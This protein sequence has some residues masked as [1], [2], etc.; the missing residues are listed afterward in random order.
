MA[1][2]YDNFFDFPSGARCAIR[3]VKYISPIRKDKDFKYYF[4]VFGDG[5][6]HREEFSYPVAPK[7]P[8]P[9]AQCRETRDAFIE[10]HKFLNQ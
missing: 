3:E 1:K 2:E 5:F 10:R 4:E 7:D 6:M 8:A 9:V